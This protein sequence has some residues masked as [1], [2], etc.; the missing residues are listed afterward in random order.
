MRDPR[1]LGCYL[2]P[3]GVPDPTVGI[4]E[5]LAAE[6]L[7]LGTVWIAERYDTKDLPALAGA[8]SQATDRVAIAAGITH[9]TT[10]H[11]MAI[12][13]MGQTLQALTN[14]RFVLGFGRSAAWRWQQYGLPAPTLATLS[15]MAN[16]LRRLWKG[17]TVTYDGPA[18]RFPELRLPQRTTWAPPPLLLAAV[19]P[20]TLELAG[21]VFDGVMLHPFLTPD[22]VARSANLVRSAAQAAGRDPSS[23][24]VYATVVVSSDSSAITSGQVVGAR[25]AG[26]LQTTGV[27]DAIVA[28]NGW[29]P[30]TLAGYRSTPI[31]EQLDGR[32]ADKSLTRTQLAELA[33]TLPASWTADSAAVGSATTCAAVLA[34]YLDAG[35]EE[36]VIHGT[37][38]P[39]LD[40]LVAAFTQQAP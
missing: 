26:Y 30:E 39:G 8:L 3:G 31:L 14:G 35:A 22:A 6:A 17:E 7:G 21:S 29:S 10:R 11:P 9:T 34:T 28:A 38:A 19:G 23:I 4:Q 5:A 36:I 2:L 1:Q 40:E 18:G 12:A 32:S 37:T 13:S 33:D 24:R 27:G 16:I 20:R 25:L 15:D